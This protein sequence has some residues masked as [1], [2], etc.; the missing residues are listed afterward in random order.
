MERKIG[1]HFY[2]CGYQYKAVE[3]DGCSGCAFDLPYLDKCRMVHAGSREVFG[4][5][6]ERLRA[7]RKNVIFVESHESALPDD[8]CH[9][10][11]Y[12]NS[13]N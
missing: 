5:C 7:D 10:D 1:E 11:K 3:H 6:C 12:G 4:E 8:F 13:I 9:I 2:W